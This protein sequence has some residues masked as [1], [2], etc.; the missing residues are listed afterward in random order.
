M[1]EKTAHMRVYSLSIY[2]RDGGGRNGKD[3]HKD[4]I[5]LAYQLDLLKEVPESGPHRFDGRDNH[6][7]MYHYHD[8]KLVPDGKGAFTLIRRYNYEYARHLTD[9]LIRDLKI[10]QPKKEN[11]SNPQDDSYTIDAV[12]DKGFEFTF[13]GCFW[14]GNNTVRNVPPEFS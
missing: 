1:A 9:I 14:I 6:I 2:S 7:R 11:P 8:I 12:D 10:Q 4:A 13:N 5:V 3:L